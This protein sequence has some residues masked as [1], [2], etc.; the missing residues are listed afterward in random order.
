MLRCI[1]KTAGTY[2][3]LPV[4]TEMEVIE[5]LLFRHYRR[6][7]PQATKVRISPM[8]VQEFHSLYGSRNLRLESRLIIRTV[9]I[10]RSDV[11]YWL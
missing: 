6:M 7:G 5:S 1:G 10:E 11:K 2:Q 3:Y 8:P 4:T 9:T